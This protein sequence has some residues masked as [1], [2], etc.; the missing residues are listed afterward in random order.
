MSNFIYFFKDGNKNLTNLLGGKGANLCEMKNLNLPIPNGFIVTTEACNKFLNTEDD[1]FQILKPQIK[2]A[3]VNLEKIT[4]KKFGGNNPLLV[5]VRSGAPVSMPG[6]MDTILNVGFNN[7][8]LKNIIAI[9]KNSTF[10]YDLYFKFIQMFSEIVMNIPRKE[11]EKLDKKEF[12]NPSEKI[13]AYKALYKSLIKKEFPDSIE[14]QIFLAVKSIFNSWNNERAILYRDLNNIDSSMGT[15]VVIQEMVFG[16]YNNLSGTG[17]M[18][19]RNPSTGENKIYG[20]Y[21]LK[22]QGEDI[23]AG[24][25]TPEDISHLE[26]DMPKIYK[27]LITIGKNLEKHYKNMLDIEFTIENNKL[28]ILQARV[29]KRTS[30]AD[31]KINLELAEENLISK[32]EAI[33]RI[34]VNSLYKIINGKFSTKALETANLIGTGL[35]GSNGVACG[36]IVLNSK[37]IPE[38]GDYILVREETSPEDIKGMYLA[39]GILTAKGGRT[40]HGAVVAR[41]MGKCC[42]TGC[43]ALTIS[44]KEKT[45]KINNTILKEG[46]IISLDGHNGN[47]YLGTVDIEKKTLN[48]DFFKLMTWTE[49]FN[50]LKV[51]VNADTPEDAKTGCYFGAKGIGLCRTEHMFFKENRIWNIRE[52]ILARNEEERNFALEKLSITQSKDFYEIFKVMNGLPV[53][54]RLL[55]PPLHEFLPKTLEEKVYL[56]NR[57]NI[58][59]LEIEKRIELLKEQNPMLGH[60]GCRLGVTFPEIY[61]MQIKSIGIA[62]NLC[63]EKNIKASVEIMIPFVGFLE[64]LQYIKSIITKTLKNHDYKVGTMIELPRACVLSDKI[65][66]EVDFFS[67]GTNDLTQ[68]TLGISRDDSA[69]FLH[70]YEEKFIYKNDPFKTIDKEGVGELLKTSISLGKR[71]NPTIKLGICG[72]HGGDPE[73]IDFFST[74]NIEYVSCS[75][76]KIPLALLASAQSEI[77]KNIKRI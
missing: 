50:N 70:S 8:V 11:F 44:E 6:M 57:M 47:I 64:E 31:L 63:K 48:E 7:D 14:E 27:E 1:F 71:E 30:E 2:S 49:D 33:L 72:E 56:S 3:L 58:T 67:Y 36:K 37:N 9:T 24:I 18:F 46:D 15:G 61:E 62:L 13:T 45:I 12:Q 4:N 75:P 26:K 52:M 41:G 76:F 51:R 68:T 25:R 22:A 34:D 66:K 55:D 69:K 5:S 43:D 65:A 40:S 20:E 28:Y 39:K 42:V 60:R 59:L 21:L 32:K 17:V 35:S 10:A 53:N 74:L 38:D 16:N 77:K 54:I 23:V 19:T 29:G 73:S